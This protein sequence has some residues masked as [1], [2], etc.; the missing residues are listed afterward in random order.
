MLPVQVAAAAAAAAAAV[1][2]AAAAAVAVMVAKE[3]AA[4]VAL[5]VVAAV[6]GVIPC[7]LRVS[8][9]CLAVTPTTT[10]KSWCAWKVRRRGRIEREPEGTRGNQR[11]PEGNKAGIHPYPVSPHPCSVCSV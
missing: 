4:A 6:G 2:A 9:Y 5:A 1:A 7:I 11:K 10:L 8:S 3:A